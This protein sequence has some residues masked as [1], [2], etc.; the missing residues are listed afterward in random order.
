MNSTRRNHR[1]ICLYVIHGVIYEKHPEKITLSDS[2]WDK[3]CLY[4]LENYDDITNV[5]KEYYLD[6]DRLK[7]GTAHHL[8]G[9]IC[10]QTNMYLGDYLSG[11]KKLWNIDIE[12]K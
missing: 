9:L 6:K 8:P 1:N 2:D 11:R 12:D 3:L 4:L 7:E 5:N 10:G